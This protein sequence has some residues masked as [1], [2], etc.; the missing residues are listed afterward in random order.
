MTDCKKVIKWMLCNSHY[1]YKSP[2][3]NL[4]RLVIVEPSTAIATML[5]L[6]VIRSIF[7]KAKRCCFSNLTPKL[8]YVKIKLHLKVKCFNKEK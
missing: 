2:A 4:K 8:F 3:C 7:P 6:N 5:Q 1:N